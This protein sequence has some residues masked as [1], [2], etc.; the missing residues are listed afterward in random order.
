MGIM[1]RLFAVVLVTLLSFGCVSHKKLRY[2]ID[3]DSDTLSKAS[4]DSSFYYKIRPG[5]VLF[6]KVQSSTDSKM[7]LFNQSFAESPNASSGSGAQAN[8][9]RGNLVDEYGDIELPMVGL[10]R[11]SGLTMKEAELAIKAKVSEYLQFVTVTVK[12]MSFR[13]SVL[14]EVFS[15]G[16][17]SIDRVQM[18][19][20]DI[21][22]YAG[23]MTDVA[24]RKKV[25]LIRQEKGKNHI[26]TLDLSSTQMLSSEHYYVRP[27]DIIYVE[28]LK[29]KVFKAN[30][31][32]ITLGFSLIA[33]TL[34][35]VAI[36]VRR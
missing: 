11:V 9:L 17:K 19:I 1:Y 5:D 7:E 31:T 23:D 4:I 30:S 29:Y 33:L 24:D 25:R 13:V 12:L 34:S 36:F 10:I 22:A 26:Y 3:L 35:L 16:V 15:P 6:I 28:P 18:S 14:G 2:M 32:T 27:G 21:L 8:L 20:Y